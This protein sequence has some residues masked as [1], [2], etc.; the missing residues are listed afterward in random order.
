MMTMA[1]GRWP[2]P[3]EQ[4]QMAVVDRLEAADEDG[5][6][7][8]A[9]GKGRARR[10]VA[11]GLANGPRS[12]GEIGLCGNAGGVR[13]RN[14]AAGHFDANVSSRA[15]ARGGARW[16]L[17]A[18]SGT[19][20]RSASAARCRRPWRARAGWAGPGGACIRCVPPAAARGAPG[21]GRPRPAP[22]AARRRAAACSSCAR[23]SPSICSLRISSTPVGRQAVHVALARGEFGRGLLVDDGLR[24]QLAPGL[25][26]TWRASAN[27][28]VL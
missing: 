24:D 5:G 6:V 23:P 9:R 17:P 15:P 27:T 25:S 3:A 7:V 2:A 16:Q 4:R 21:P 18:L 12:G 8:H 10:A 13:W 28:S 26:L 1:C 11:A 20:R 14:S 22:A 19:R